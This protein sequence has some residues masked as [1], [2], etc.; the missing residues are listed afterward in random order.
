MSLSPDLLRILVCPQSKA[1]LEH[2]AGPPEVL[3]CRESRLVYQV[4]DGIPV[5]LIDEAEPLDETKYP[6]AL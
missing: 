4:Q 5:M 2:H 3:I 1:P 6:A